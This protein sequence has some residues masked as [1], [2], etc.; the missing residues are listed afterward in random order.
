MYLNKNVPQKTQKFFK[1][2][3]L[4]LPAALFLI[5]IM[6]MIVAAINQINEMNASAYGREWLSMSAFYAAES[7]AQTAALY[8]LNT[9]AVAPACDGNFINGLTPAGM[10]FCSI[11]VTCSSQ[12]VDALNYF[13]FTSTATCGEG[14]D[15]A[16]RII[17]VRVML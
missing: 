7:G 17:Q 13:T 8:V 1:Q 12:T 11:N 10:S 16:T 3:G 2:K 4:G 14:P 15:A 6:V 5:I 9:T